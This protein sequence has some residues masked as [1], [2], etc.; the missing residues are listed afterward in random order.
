M[1]L[2]PRVWF[3]IQSKV[4]SGDMYQWDRPLIMCLAEISSTEQWLQA[5]LS[6]H[7]F[8]GLITGDW[9]IRTTESPPF[10]SLQDGAATVCLLS[11][12]LCP[13]HCMPFPI[14]L[15][16]IPKQRSVENGNQWSVRVYMGS[17]DGEDQLFLIRAASRELGHEPMGKEGQFW[18]GSSEDNRERKAGV[19]ERL[20]DNVTQ[21]LEVASSRNKE[22]KLSAV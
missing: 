20:Q 13:L 19:A 3:P 4:S 7:L 8:Q 17:H 18:W 22:D 1:H 16:P 2:V 12:T 11:E 21:G 14:S 9:I 15:T 5:F 10:P 6:S